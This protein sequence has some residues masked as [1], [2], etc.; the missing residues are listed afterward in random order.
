MGQEADQ[1]GVFMCSSLLLGCHK[2]DGIPCRPESKV[3]G[4][5]VFRRFDVR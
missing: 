5:C 1:C 2:E 3:E 4:A